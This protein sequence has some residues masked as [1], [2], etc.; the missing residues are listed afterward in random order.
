MKPLRKRLLFVSVGLSP[1]GG[2][3][4]TAGRLLLRTVRDFAE[5][6]DVELRLLTLGHRDEVPHGVDGQGFEGDRRALARAVWK[7]QFAEGFR[8][9]VYDFLGVARIQG[10]LPRAFAARYL[11][12]VHGIEV[13]RPL[14]GARRR[15]LA[16]AAVR[17]ANSSHTVE[18]LRVHNPGA[19]LV[20]PLHLAMQDASADDDGSQAPDEQLLARLG[21][22]FVLIVGRMEGDRYKGHE[23]LLAAL[24]LLAPAHPELRLVIV[25]DG[26]DRGRL[27]ARASELGVADRAVF[28][29]FVDAATLSA[30]YRRSAVFAM[31][32]DGEGF[33]LVYLEAMRAAKPCVAL[34]GS[35]AAEIIVDSKTGLLIEPGVQSLEC[36]LEELLRDPAASAAMGAAGRER[37]HQAFR[38]EL[39]AAGLRPHL[40]TLLAEA[41]P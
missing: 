11:L 29:G 24:A 25:G 27:E 6:R 20:T 4:A 30:I 34:A 9:Q 12:Y 40:E 7:A 8:H 22:G 2:G 31:P 5:E 32:S 26:K 1:R 18:R 36:A 3:I 13:W 15:A 21:E 38:P 10:I 19:P 41:R 28:T 39:F 16:S 37:W 17:L 33:G 23:D 14:A 35:A